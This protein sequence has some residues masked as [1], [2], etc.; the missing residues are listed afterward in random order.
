MKRPFDFWYIV[1]VILDILLKC[2]WIAMSIGYIWYLID[3]FS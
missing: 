3:K 2:A 1:V